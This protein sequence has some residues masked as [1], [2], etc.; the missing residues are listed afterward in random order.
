M[1]ND[2]NCYPGR[3][4]KQE[5][6]IV[7][8]GFVVEALRA[9]LEAVAVVLVTARGELCGHCKNGEPLFDDIETA[10]PKGMYHRL[11]FNPGHQLRE[12]RARFLL[13]ALG[14]PNVK[15]LLEGVKDGNGV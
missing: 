7:E 14:R 1:G 12:C 8:A 9:D 13:E 15:A 2:N 3:C 6:T 10:D 5:A 4:E 11:Y